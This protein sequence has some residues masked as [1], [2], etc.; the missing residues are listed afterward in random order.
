MFLKTLKIPFFIKM[1]IRTIENN[2]VNQLVN[3]DRNYDY[4]LEP[5]T[6]TLENASLRS[7]GLVYINVQKIISRETNRTK[8]Y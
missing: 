7:K 2:S 8:P 4:F 1:F 3:L 6:L 5:N